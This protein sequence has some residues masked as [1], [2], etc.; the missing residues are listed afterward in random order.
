[1]EKNSHLTWI[2][3]TY[4]KLNIYSCVLVPRNKLWFESKIPT[5]TEFWN[6]I[7]KERVTGYEHRKP[8]K[9]RPRNPPPESKQQTVV[10]KITTPK[11]DASTPNLSVQT[12]MPT[13]EL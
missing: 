11:F 7:L 12:E 2:T 6:I 9:R 5:I 13:L 4:W 8:K 3:N 1:M 10:I